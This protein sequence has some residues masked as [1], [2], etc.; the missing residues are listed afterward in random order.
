VLLQDPVE[1]RERL[2]LLALLVGEE[3][4]DVEREIVLTE[5]GVVLADRS[6]SLPTP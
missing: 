1:A 6:A 4:V 2:V 5:P 3:A